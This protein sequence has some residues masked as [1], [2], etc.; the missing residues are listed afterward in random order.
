MVSLNEA[1]ESVNV[2]SSILQAW[3]NTQRENVEWG[4]WIYHIPNDGRYG[5]NLK[6]DRQNSSIVLTNRNDLDRLSEA[7]IL[8]DFHCHPG[9]TPASC[10]PSDADIRGAKFLEYDRLVFTY[11]S[12][13]VY[14]D[15]LYRKA[16][17]RA[18]P[19]DFRNERNEIIEAV[20]WMIR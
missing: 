9:P 15:D 7:R 18:T 3:N 1:L 11:S 5:I 8:A 19:F 10:R 4:G 12:S 13:T 20:M 2:R 16:L 17:A 6:T 14:P